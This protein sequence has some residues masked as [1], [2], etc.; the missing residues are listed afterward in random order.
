MPCSCQQKKKKVI[1]Q[2][3]NAKPYSVKQSR[4]KIK[5]LGWKGL[6]SIL[7]RSCSIRFL[8]IPIFL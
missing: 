7:A 8:F 3:D 1:L 5:V 6:S 2:R 4:E